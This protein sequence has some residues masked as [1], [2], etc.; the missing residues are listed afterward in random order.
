MSQSSAVT[1]NRTAQRCS[2]SQEE[3]DIIQKYYTKFGTEVAMKMLRL[4][5]YKRS[6]A[7]IKSYVLRKNIRC[8][9]DSRFQAGHTPYNK[10]ATLRPD[11]AEKIK[12]TQFKVGHDNGRQ[13]PIGMVKMRSEYLYI[14]VGTP[15]K[16]ELYHRY[17]WQQQNGKIPDGMIVVFIDG[18]QENVCL[19]NLE[20][21]SR[22]EHARRIAKSIDPKV[23]HTSRLKAVATRKKNAADKRRKALIAQYGTL[24]NDLAMG[25][26]L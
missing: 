23:R 5:G 9:R 1:Y 14:K 26:K 21:I 22:Q 8:E 15:S 11:V 19:E 2:F 4:K 24:N 12:H 17:V 13:E 16:W 18:N 7:S 25:E 10:G 20:V 3:A 6:I